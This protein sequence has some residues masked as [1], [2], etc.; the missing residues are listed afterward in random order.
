MAD[1]GGGRLRSTPA[2]ESFIASSPFR[3]SP[4]PAPHP[5]R[6]GVRRGVLADADAALVLCAPFPARG[7]GRV[8]QAKPY[9]PPAWSF[10]FAGAL[11]PALPGRR[12]GF[13]AQW[14]R[15]LLEVES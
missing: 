11:S 3:P 10:K 7:T 8:G 2:P 4:M 15:E 5:P 1:R 6:F 13:S 9:P 12:P 14:R